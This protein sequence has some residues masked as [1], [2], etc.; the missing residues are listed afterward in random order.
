MV[1]AG[2]I[3][4]GVVGL[5]VGER[6]VVS[7]QAIENCDVLSICDL[8]RTRLDEIG[9]RYGVA[10]RSTD[11]RAVTENPDIDIV[12][13][14][15]YDDAHAEQAL[16]ALRH[17]KHVMIEKPIVL[18]R[19]DARRLF[20]AHR[21]TGKLIS[22]NLILRASPRFQEVKRLAQQG[23]FGE[24]F[25]VEGDYIHQ[26]LHKLTEGWRGKMDFY[27]V[28]YGGGIHLIDLMRWIVNDEVETVAGMSNK[29]LTRDTGYAFD[30]T[31]VLLLRFSRGCIA[32][33]MTTLGPQRTKFHSLNVYGT[34]ATFLNDM[35]EGRLFTGATPDDE[36]AV[37][38]PYPAMEKGD[39]LPNF[40]EAVRS[41]REPLVTTK[42]V[43][44]VMDICFAAVRS[45]DEQR[46]VPVEY[47]DEETP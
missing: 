30:D 31:T 23:S 24:I 42:D 35:P 46:T 17:G 33:N 26:I 15:S 34:Q 1:N 19:N 9:D 12:S 7:Y 37:T 25:Y 29:I 22:S 39:L 27:S 16:S 6:H 38:A 10:Q 2:R 45:M 44:R 14:C 40:V 8:D 21:E 13:I 4:V 32:K 41:G 18:N 20:D 28:V 43:F 5:G 47:L 36:E 3:G 11:Y